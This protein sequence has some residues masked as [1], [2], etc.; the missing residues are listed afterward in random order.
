MYNQQPS[1]NQG[2]SQPPPPP[3]VEQAPVPQVTDGGYGYVDQQPQ[4]GGG[5]NF[6]NTTV[7][8]EDG[9]WWEADK[10][11]VVQTGKVH[12]NEKKKKGGYW[13]VI[14]LLLDSYGNQTVTQTS[15]GW[16]KDETTVTETDQYGSTT[17]VSL[18]HY[19]FF[20]CTTC[21]LTLFFFRVGGRN[22]LVLK[23]LKNASLF[24]ALHNYLLVAPD[25]Y[26]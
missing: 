1:Y 19:S 6:T 10:Q 14:F 18:Y 16:F 2:Y 8:N 17:V 7:I 3:P 22:R 15:D 4:Y 24:F 21:V 20:K 13:L 11:T 5:E 23:E 12:P 26:I 9:H 25:Y